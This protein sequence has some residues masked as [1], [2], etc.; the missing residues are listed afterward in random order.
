M[1]FQTS[2][3]WA[4]ESSLGLRLSNFSIPKSLR[5]SGL[6]GQFCAQLRSKFDLVSLRLIRLTLYSLSESIEAFDDVVIRSQQWIVPCGRFHCMF[7]RPRSS[8]V[9]PL[10]WLK[11]HFTVHRHDR[12]S[13]DPASGMFSQFENPA[14]KAHLS[15]KTFQLLS[16]LSPIT[17]SSL[18]C[19]ISRLA[20]STASGAGST[21]R[22]LQ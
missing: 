10:G 7:P 16:S 19:T 17:E 9:V 18:Y 4:P 11:S 12:P 15:F 1:N 5:D 13:A 20:Q 3:L 22:L 6:N 2:D 21:Y 8:P 14:K